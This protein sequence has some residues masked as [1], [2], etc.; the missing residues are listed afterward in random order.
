MPP[1]YSVYPD[2]FAPI[3]TLAEERRVMKLA[4]WGLPSLKDAADPSKVN[5][6]TTNIRYP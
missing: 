2:Y 4:R 3:C 5:K 6:G 1:L